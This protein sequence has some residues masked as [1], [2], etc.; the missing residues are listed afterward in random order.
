VSTGIWQEEDTFK[1]G[2]LESE[3]L[4]NACPLE[5][6][7]HKQSYYSP[8]FLGGGYV[9]HDKSKKGRQ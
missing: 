7:S 2:E 8:G 6:Q 5:E 4:D 1:D 9:V 3:N